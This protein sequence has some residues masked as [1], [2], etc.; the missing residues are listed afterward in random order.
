MPIQYGVF[1]DREQVTN[2]ERVYVELDACVPSA[3][4]VGMYLVAH[5]LDRKGHRRHVL[6]FPVVGA[7][8]RMHIK[9]VQEYLAELEFKGA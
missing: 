9:P 4:K 7:D 8:L 2:I 5:D 1:L 6:D 3:P